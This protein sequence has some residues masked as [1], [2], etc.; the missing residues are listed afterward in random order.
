MKTNRFN[1]KWARVFEP[2]N[3]VMMFFSPS[4]RTLLSFPLLLQPL[5]WGACLIFSPITMSKFKSK[6]IAGETIE[7]AANTM[8]QF[9]AGI[10]IRIMER[11]LSHYGEGYIIHICNTIHLLRLFG[12]PQGIKHFVDYVVFLNN[13]VQVYRLFCM[14]DMSFNQVS[15]IIGGCLSQFLYVLIKMSLIGSTELYKFWDCPWWV[16]SNGFK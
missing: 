16:I 11:S 12:V 8:S 6:M 1:P 2:R 9:M 14:N 15:N 10:G 13:L 7:D 4:L 3:F 5:N